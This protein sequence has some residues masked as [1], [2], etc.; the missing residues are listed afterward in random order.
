MSVARRH[1]AL[2]ASGP[3]TW[4]LRALLVVALLYLIFPLVAVVVNSFSESAYGEWPPPGYSLKWYEKLMAQDQFPP[5]LVLSLTLAAGATV[6]GLVVG[7]MAAVALA[8]WPSRRMDGARA[9][10]LSPMAV[11]KIAIGFAAFLLF[12]KL[13]VYKSYGSLLV[14]HTV[15]IMPFTLSIVG[16]GLVSTNRVLEEAARDLGAGPIGAF[17]RVTIPQMTR[18]LAAAAVLSFILSFDEFD[19]TVLMANPAQPT[20]PFWMYLYLQKFSDPSMAA[21]STVLIASSLVLGVALWLFLRGD[22][23][24]AREIVPTGE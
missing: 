21:L 1:R 3:G 13:G 20:L 24:V 12:L 8:R 15:L 11:P 6:L 23:A 5:A 4:A 18:S 16:S 14:A 19:A 17:V 7:T 9:L 22:A 2:R 10:L